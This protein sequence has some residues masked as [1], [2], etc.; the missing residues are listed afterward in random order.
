MERKKDHTATA[1]VVGA[2]GTLQVWAAWGLQVAEPAS[3]LTL[4][5]TGVLTWGGCVYFAVKASREASK[6]PFEAERERERMRAR[7]PADV[8]GPAA[9][10]DPPPDRAP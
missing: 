4:L 10:S 6:S 3:A 1:Q 5:V 2:A 8:R 7:V 9:A